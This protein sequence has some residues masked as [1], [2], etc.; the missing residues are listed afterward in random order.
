MSGRRILKVAVGG[1][2]GAALY[3][4]AESRVIDDAPRPEAYPVSAP[5]REGRVV[6][7]PTWCV[8]GRAQRMASLREEQFD[9]LVVGGRAT[10][11]GTALDCAKRGLTV[12]LVERDDFAAGTSSRSTKLIHGGIRYLAQAFQS[13]VPP[14]SPLDVLRNLRFNW[15]YLSIVA[16]D[17]HERSFMIKSASDRRRA[18]SCVAV[19]KRRCRPPS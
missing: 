16:A 13:K 9:V 8:E 3:F 4:A 18:L 1:A 11:T 12:A 5:N 14:E 19:S 6:V 15:D 2:C 17:L 10:G 7:H